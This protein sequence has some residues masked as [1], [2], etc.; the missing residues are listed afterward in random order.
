MQSSNDL[1]VLIIDDNNAI[2]GFLHQTLTHLGVLHVVEASSGFAGMESFKDGAFNIVFLDLGLPDIDGN[3]VLR[4]LK[5]MDEKV[6]VVIV[7]SHS[8]VDLVKESVGCGAQGYI[9][10]PFSPKKIAAIIKKYQK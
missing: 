2:R 8:S 10:K 5:K 4:Q 7:S 1:S 9:V 3:E 6:S